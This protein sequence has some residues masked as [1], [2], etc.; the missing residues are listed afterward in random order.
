MIEKFLQE[1]R[2]DLNKQSRTSNHVS[3][4]KGSEIKDS[5]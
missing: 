1:S 2:T 5:K 3:L 4:I